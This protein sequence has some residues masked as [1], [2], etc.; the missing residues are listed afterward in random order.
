MGDCSKQA[1]EMLANTGYKVTNQRARILEILLENTDKHMSAEEIYE[2]IKGEKG[3]IGLATIYRALELF[4][5]LDIIHK[6]NF[7]DGRSRYELKEE[8]HHHHHLICSK[9]NG[10]FEVAEDLLDQLEEKIEKQ[11]QFKITGHHLKFYG[12]CQ[13]CVEG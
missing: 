10:V 9:C 12:I 3:D 4:E 1:R 5:E 13:N 2:I 8:D 7:G 11:Y 6:L